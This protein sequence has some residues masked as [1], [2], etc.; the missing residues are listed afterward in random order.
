MTTKEV[1]ERFKISITEIRKLCSESLISAYKQN[2]RWIINDNIDFL[3]TKDAVIC[4]LWQI[5]NIKNN[6]GYALSLKHIDSVQDIEKCLKYLKQQGLISEYNKNE[7]EMK[8][9]LRSA[10]I[11]S[12]GM[13]MIFTSQKLSKNHNVSISISLF[14]GGFS[15]CSL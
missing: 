8:S 15:L 14:S 6:L 4:L 2:D 11:T 1:S 9:I 10:I 13:E 7:N 5:V 3:M 12:V